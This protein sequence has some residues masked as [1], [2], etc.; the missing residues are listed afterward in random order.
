MKVKYICTAEKYKTRNDEEKTL[1]HR[2]GEIL[3]WEDDKGNISVKLYN[4][5]NQ[6]YFVFDKQNKKK[7]EGEDNTPF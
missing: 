5:P 4:N 3:F 7:N 2:V 6:K 1:W